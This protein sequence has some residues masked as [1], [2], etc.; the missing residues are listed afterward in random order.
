MKGLTSKQLKSQTGRLLAA[1]NFTLDHA[2]F[3]TT[4]MQKKVKKSSLN[5]IAGIMFFFLSRD[6]YT[7]H[8]AKNIFITSDGDTRIGKGS[9]KKGEVKGV[10][11]I[12]SRGSK[13]MLKRVRYFKI[14]ISNKSHQLPRFSRY[15]QR[16]GSM[17][18]IIKSASYLMSWKNFSKI[19]SLLLD[20][21]GSIV[22][23]DSGIPYKYFKNSSKWELAYFGKYHR[24]LPVFKSR[25]QKDLRRDLEKYSRG[26]VPFAYG[27]GYGYPDMTYHL[28]WARK[29]RKSNSETAFNGEKKNSTDLF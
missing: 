12:F 21:S 6:G 17:T 9:D 23:D 27:Y 15:V 7:I 8:D 18:T 1:I 19:R 4:D 13:E 5:G 10:E 3:V 26:M 22:Q 24:P 25:Y 29:K 14:D 11:I 2:F 20:R 28:L 16:Y